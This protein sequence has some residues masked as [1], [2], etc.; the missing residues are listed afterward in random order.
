[1][2]DSSARIQDVNLQFKLK[3]LFLDFLACLVPGIV[4]VI[5]ITLLIGG[6][7]YIGTNSIA[8]ISSDVLNSLAIF[9]NEILSIIHIPFL[10][11]ISNYF[12]FLYC[13]SSS[14]ST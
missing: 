10:G 11:H 4:F 3:D 12:Y 9:S 6:L 5:S 13:W 7:F 8:L 1:M 14:L 2:N